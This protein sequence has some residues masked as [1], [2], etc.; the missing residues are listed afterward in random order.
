[1]LVSRIFLKNNIAIFGDSKSQ[2]STS[3]ILNNSSNNALLNSISEHEVN[4]LVN[5]N[6]NHNLTSEL[7]EI[8]E[9]YVDILQSNQQIEMSKE[10]TTVVIIFFL[11]FDKITKNVCRPTFCKNLQIIIF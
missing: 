8:A 1:M 6:D 4:L 2:T 7:N 11:F 10:D 5:G 9:K 3:N